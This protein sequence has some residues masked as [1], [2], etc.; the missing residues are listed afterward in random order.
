MTS[1]ISIPL[2]PLRRRFNVDLQSAVTIEFDDS[3]V[4]EYQL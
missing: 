1:G 2:L 4:Y 3:A